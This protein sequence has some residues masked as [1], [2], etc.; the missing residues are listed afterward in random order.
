MTPRSLW[1]DHLGSLSCA[2]S[3]LTRGRYGVWPE[4]SSRPDWRPSY[5]EATE[6]RQCFNYP[7]MEFGL[8]CPA[9]LTQCLLTR[10]LQRKDN[11]WSWPEL[12]SR[13]D[14]RPSYQEATEKRQYMEFGLN[15][16]AG[17]TPCL[18]TRKLQRNGKYRNMEL[19]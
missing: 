1:E 15:C 17:L 13:P 4:L 14:W 7:D 10:K 5:R 6:K 19:A 2:Y 8:N 16:P 3:V 11:I 18:L 9:G 12:S